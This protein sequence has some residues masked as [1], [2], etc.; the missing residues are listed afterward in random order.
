MT[1]RIEAYIE[2]NQPRFIE[3][4][5]EFMRFPSVSAQRAHDG[6]TRACAEWLV[7][8]LA[9][10]GFDAQ[11]VD[12]GGQPIVR[13]AAKGKAAFSRA[14]ARRTI[15]A[16]SSRMSRPSRACWRP[17]ASFPVRWSS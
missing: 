9:K 12:V 17:K 2:E 7:A 11:L 16:S 1:D 8:H 15:K 10:L 4:L 13:A 6:D 5:K 3:E 14:A